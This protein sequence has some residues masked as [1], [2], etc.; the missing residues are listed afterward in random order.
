M[1]IEILSRLWI[2]DKKHAKCRIHHNLY[3][4]NYNFWN[5][6]MHSFQRL[7]ETSTRTIHRYIAQ[8]LEPIILI[9]HDIHSL[10][11]AYVV[12]VAYI[13][14]YTDVSVKDAIRSIQTKT[15]PFRLSKEAKQC[16]SIFRQT[17]AGRVKL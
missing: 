16:L 13:V 11:T 4:H 2:A 10:H 9:D 8:S 17:Y 14:R 1:R 3:L 12:V 7:L 6:D 5:Q 15:V